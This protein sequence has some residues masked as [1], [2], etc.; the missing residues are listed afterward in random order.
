MVM[1]VVVSVGVTRRDESGNVQTEGWC[2]AGLGGIECETSHLN[3]G[4][5]IRLLRGRR[6]MMHWS[7]RA[8]V[9]RRRTTLLARR[10]RLPDE[11]LGGESRLRKDRCVGTSGC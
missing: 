7:K 10:R 4:V 1:K 2:C 5:A 6:T 11:V 9:A 8:R 3:T